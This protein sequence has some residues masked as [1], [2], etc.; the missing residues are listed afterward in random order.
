MVLKKK[1]ILRFFLALIISVIIIQSGSGQAV[2]EE[3]F[4]DR[5]FRLLEGSNNS[6]TVFY[7]TGCSACKV[8]LPKIGELSKD[9][10]DVCVNYIDIYNSNENRTILLAFGDKYGLDY[11]AYPVIFTGNITVLEGGNEIEKYLR[12]VFEAHK[13]GNIPDIEFESSLKSN[14]KSIIRSDNITIS[15]NDKNISL[16]MVILA[17]LADGINPCAISVLALLL[18]ALSGMKTRKQII[19]HGISYTTAVFLFYFI[20]GLGIIS[21]IQTAG[22]SYYFSVIAGFI[23]LTAGIIT[24]LEGIKNESVISLGIPDS[25]KTMI[26]RVIEKTS[27]PAAFALG[28]M[29]GLF[30]LPCTGGIY[31]AILGLLSS[32]MTFYEGLPYLL[33]YNL[34]FILPLLAIITAVAFGLS[35]ERVDKWRDSNKKILKIGLGAFLIVIALYILFI[36]LL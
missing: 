1:H 34:M 24:L 26:K 2:Y 21:F 8:T 35:P 27:L 29:V 14:P 33:I 5:F 18:V 3:D 9:Y 17:G 23:A 20:A 31:I 28:I 16:A 6:V 13:K 25:K 11:P 4:G 19:L 36:Y 30:E 15:D 7:S 10:P 22:L 12:M 32:E